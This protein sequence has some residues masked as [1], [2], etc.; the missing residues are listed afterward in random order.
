MRFALV[1]VSLCFACSTESSKTKE[2]TK[3]SVKTTNTA[4]KKTAAK[5]KASKQSGTTTKTTKAMGDPRFLI[6][7]PTAKGQTSVKVLPLA[8]YKMNVDYPASLTGNKGQPIASLS[9][10]RK[11][12]SKLTEKQLRFNLPA[13]PKKATEVK[14]TIDFSVCNAQACEMVEKEITWTIKPDA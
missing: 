9:G 1:L 12:P 4:S 8:D 14:A 13:Q 3:A 5:P 6:Q 7:F 2:P 11:E 10:I